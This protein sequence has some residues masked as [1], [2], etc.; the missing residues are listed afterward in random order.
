MAEAIFYSTSKLLV[1]LKEIMFGFLLN[2]KIVS[3]LQPGYHF[4]PFVSLQEEN[5]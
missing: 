1:F 4:W 2:E 3:E 5:V